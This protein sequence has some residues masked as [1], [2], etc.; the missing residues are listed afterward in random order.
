MS[1]TVSKL[2]TIEA[3][4]LHLKL[5]YGKDIIG[6]K[7]IESYKIQKPGLALA[8]YTKH[9][10]S[11]RIQILGETEISYL[12]SLD[13]EER[14]RAIINLCDTD[15]SCLVVTKDLK[16][17]N[18]VLK[19]V[20]L[21]NIPLLKTEEDTENAITGIQCFLESKLA[22]FE[23]LHGNFMDVYGIGILIIGR[24][25]IGKS[26]CALE[27]I[28]K[29]HRLISDDSVIVRLKQNHLVGKCDETFQYFI[30]LRG[31]G[32][33]NVK[34]IFG[35]GSI[36]MEKVINF[37]IKFV[38]WEKNTSYDRLGLGNDY[39]KLFNIK[40]PLISLPV[41]L[42]R[43]MS[44][45]VETAAKNYLLKSIGQNVAEEFNAR[46]IKKISENREILEKKLKEK[47]NK[48]S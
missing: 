28:N 39:F 33:I 43:D 31:L 16:I 10:H 15:I 42:G 44:V 25:G 47:N 3:K 40:L 2:L 32:I 8:G 34:E 1:I 38:D 19:V 46:L 14:E 29:G 20:K 11:G 23:I 48:Q 13:S 27:L 12:W 17:P 36:T 21:Y 6:S 24:S 4:Q 30:E 45:L 37:V 22:P 41:Y 18:E 35:I 26:E 7:S 5:V 9:I